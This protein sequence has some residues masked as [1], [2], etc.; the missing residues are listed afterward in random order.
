MPIVSERFGAIAIL[1]C[2][3]AGL[4]LAAAVRIPPSMRDRD[5][6]VTDRPRFV[7]V[8]SELIDGVTYRDTTGSQLK[9][10][11]RW[12]KI[13]GEIEYQEMRGQSLWKVGL[14]A[15]KSGNYL[16]AAQRFQAVA[17]GER[18]WQRAYGH[19]YTGRAWEAAGAY[20]RAADSFARFVAD[21]SLQKHRWF[22]DALYFQ[23][24]NLA[25]VRQA[26]E[27]RAVKDQLLKLAEQYKGG[28]NRNLGNRCEA[29]GKA[30]EAA[31]AVV[32]GDMREAVKLAKR[33]V[34]NR[35][36]ADINFH[37]GSFWAGF[38]REEGEFAAAAEE[39]R[40][41]L[42]I[43]EEAHQ[44]AVLSLGYGICLKEAGK[45]EQAQFEL[46]KL[47]ALPYGSPEERLQARYYAGV[48]K[49]EL[50][51]R[52]IKDPKEKR[53]E[54]GHS[55]AREARR[56]LKAAAASPVGG[57]FKDLS[58][59]YLQQLPPSPE[60]IAAAE[61]AAAEAETAATTDDPSALE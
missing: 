54:F 9:G 55:E 51:Q 28:G 43:V 58:Q 23:G 1:S 48:A 8:E 57:K 40:R 4:A 10:P 29:R 21:E 35:E 41:L 26:E 60:E 39:Y 5:L 45:L 25:R 42:D 7:Y 13:N 49:W 19:L 37:W 17:A 22:Q 56:M 44:R 11:V 3:A 30:I 50:S 27:A 2:L 52:L 14:D 24:V 16:E 15:L 34:W 33:I 47:D 59:Q 20:E 12:S 36:D 61:A 6:M 53:Q 32:D 18:E 46:L 31:L 38:L